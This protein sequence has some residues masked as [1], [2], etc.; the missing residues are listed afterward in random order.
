MI[1]DEHSVQPVL[2]Y[3]Q[4]AVRSSPAAPT[5]QRPLAGKVM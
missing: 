3:N 4:Q 5:L 1:P 2:A